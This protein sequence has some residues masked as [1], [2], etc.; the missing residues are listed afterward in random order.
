MS[1]NNALGI[2]IYF[3][4]VFLMAVSMVF[5][6]EK[7]EAGTLTG[8]LPANSTFNNV[9][10][11]NVTSTNVTSTNVS[12]TNMS[13][14]NMVMNGRYI[15]RNIAPTLQA[16]SGWDSG[17]SISGA[18]G[19]DSFYLTLAAASGVPTS[20]GGTITMPQATS[21]AGWRCIAQQAAMP[22]GADRMLDLAA[23]GVTQVVATN[24]AISTGAAMPVSAGQAVRVICRGY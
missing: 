14:I 18:N 4:T 7:S 17:A 12:A 8:A 2:L 19:T 9:T 11:T 21:G 6:A 22:I 20:T 23:S 1:K 15:A 24:R 3:A 10:A 13:A 5:W 16:G